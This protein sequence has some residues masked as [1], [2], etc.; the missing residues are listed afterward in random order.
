MNAC[1]TRNSLAS[2]V[3]AFRFFSFDFADRATNETVALRLRA[4]VRTL[5]LFFEPAETGLAAFDLKTATLTVRHPML[6]NLSPASVIFC[7]Y[8]LN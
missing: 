4:D 5:Q 1:W 7:R 8:Q 2:S 6:T 3:I